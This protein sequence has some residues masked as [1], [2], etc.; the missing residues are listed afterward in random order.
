MEAAGTAGAGWVGEETAWVG[1]GWVAM[2]ALGSEERVAAGCSSA[3]HPRQAHFAHFC[4]RSALSRCSEIAL[5]PESPG[6]PWQGWRERGARKKQWGRR[7]ALRRWARQHAGRRRRRLARRWHGAGGGHIPRGGG[8]AH[9]RGAGRRL[10]QRRRWA[11]RRLVQRRTALGRGG[12]GGRRRR[13]RRRGRG[14]WER[15]RCLRNRSNDGSTGCVVAFGVERR[16]GH[17]AI[18]GEAEKDLAVGARR[19]RLQCRG[20]PKAQRPRG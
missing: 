6:R 2:A 20:G 17:G 7:A 18:V 10:L 15:H 19:P 8:R 5:R 3:A 11:G 4:E 16:F 14:R 12:H 9:G 13:A 1:G